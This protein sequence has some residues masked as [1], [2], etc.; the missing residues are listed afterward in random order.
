MFPSLTEIAAELYRT[1]P[2]GTT[3]IWVTVH[4]RP[5]DRR[6]PQLCIRTD[7]AGWVAPPSC[8]AV[9]LV[10]SGRAHAL[11][12]GEP[13][14][15]APGPVRMA[16]VIGRDGQL[17]AH[18]EFADGHVVDDP[19]KGGLMIDILRRTFE[20]PTDPPEVPS[21]TFLSGVWLTR[22][23]LEGERSRRLGWST[24]IRLHPIA[25]ALAET[26]EDIPLV[27]L[28]Q[29]LRVA[30]RAWTWARL[31]TLAVESDGFLA[32][33]P[34]D[35]ADWMDEGIFSRWVLRDQPTTA[36]L[37][38]AVAGRVTREALRQTRLLLADTGALS[39][40]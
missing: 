4:D 11:P 21:D 31:R 5:G 34:P 36:S 40:A 28:S 13:P 24:V 26:G 10:A 33:I 15:I 27:T 20:L 17:A 7:P 25:E 19:P 12:G 8:K 2:A 29:I 37:L 22:I 35:L 38:H 39:A 9:A 6:G 32:G 1:M 18:A 30:G 23:L 14:D 16:C 3:P